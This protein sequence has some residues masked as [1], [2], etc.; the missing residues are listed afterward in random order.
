MNINIS[1]RKAFAPIAICTVSVIFG[2]SISGMVVASETASLE[3]FTGAGTDEDPYIITNAEEL[4]AMEEDLSASYVLAAD[5]NATETADWNKGEGFNPIG[6]NPDNPFKGSLDGR[7]HIIIGLSITR[8]SEDYVGLFGAT[9]GAEMQSIYIRDANIIGKNHVG[10][11]VGYFEG[12]EIRSMSV[13][14]QIKG[15]RI[16]GGIAGTVYKG[17]LQ[18]SRSTAHV[19]GSEYIGGVLGFLSTDSTVLGSASH[20]TIQ[21]KDKGAG[22]LIGTPGTRSKEVRNSFSTA[23][24]KGNT[25]TGAVFG[26]VSDS[27]SPKFSEVYWDTKKSG[28]EEGIGTGPGSV[29]GLTT[30]QMTGPAAKENME[31]LFVGTDFMPTDG[32]PVLEQHVQDVDVSVTNSLLSVEDTTDITVTLDLYD[33]STTTATRTADYEI[34]GA[35]SIENGTVVPSE[36]GETDVSV[37]VNGKTDTATL[38]VRTPADISMAD[39]QLDTPATLANTTASVSATLENDG[40]MP[41]SEHVTLTADGES[42]AAETVHVS[43]HSE[44]RATF[45]W[46]VDEVG[47]YDVTI[48]ARELGEL[49]VLDRDVVSLRNVTALETVT[50]GETYDIVST[51]ENTADTAVSVPVSVGGDGRTVEDRIRV[52]PGESTHTFDA[53]A[54][55]PAGRTI[56]NAVSLGATTRRANTTVLTPATFDVVDVDAPETADVGETITFSATV[57]NTG[58]IAGSTEITVNVAGAERRS[59]PVRLDGG[60]QREIDFAMT[61]ETAGTVEYAVRTGEDSTSGSL[62]VQADADEQTTTAATGSETDSDDGTHVQDDTRRDEPIRTDSTSTTDKTHTAASGPGFGS[63][64]ALLAILGGGLLTARDH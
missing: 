60:E 61:V 51:V 19:I 18:S 8:V 47:T 44:T 45:E 6:S 4:Q 37:S 20:G 30:D 9:K 2:M 50:P 63:V 36:T 38:D 24:V 23:I 46:S 27:F 17:D 26:W 16:V 28:I 3:E 40:G 39:A 5:I 49:T 55:E 22:G 14:G 58:D 25:E 1:H 35:A 64:G 41:T 21:S 42:I 54:T 33:G 13:E 15:I 31:Y 12:G 53:T 29:T 56:V 52:T 7:D 11:G 34:D 62:S 10:G 57:T 48:G 32:Y 43:G 59:E